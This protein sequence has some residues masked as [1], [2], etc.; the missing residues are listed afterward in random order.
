MEE[1]KI[2]RYCPKNHNKPCHNHLCQHQC[3]IDEEECR[4]PEH[5][6]ECP[7]TTLNCRNPLC[8]GREGH[9]E[10]HKNPWEQKKFIKEL[11]L[12]MKHDEPCQDRPVIH[13]HNT[14][15]NIFLTEEEH[16]HRKHPRKPLLVLLTLI[17]KTKYIMSDITLTLG[18]TPKDGTFALLDTVTGGILTGVSFSKQAVGAN[19]NPAAATFAIDPADTTGNSVLPTPLAAGSGT[20]GFAATATYTDSTGATQTDVPFTIVKNF[21]VVLGADGVTLDILF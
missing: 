13:I 3:F 14:I 1:Q 6:K 7:V 19:S 15:E 20:I 9:C 5:H 17:N 16:H 21:T 8:T 18:A 12:E 11:I 2:Y 10:L 4:K